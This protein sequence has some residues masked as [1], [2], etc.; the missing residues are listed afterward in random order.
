[1]LC[2]EKGQADF[3]GG[4]GDVGVGDSGIEADCGRRVRIIWGDLYREGPQAT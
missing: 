3:A 2:C 4:E 1:M